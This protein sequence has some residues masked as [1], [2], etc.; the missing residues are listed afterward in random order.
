MKKL[1]LFSIV[2]LIFS[3]LEIKADSDTGLHH[4][5]AEL[6]EIKTD[7]VVEKDFLYNQ[8]ALADTYLYGK[9]TRE[10]QWDKIKACLAQVHALRAQNDSSW[11][12]LQNK[13]NLNGKPAKAKDYSI[14]VYRDVVDR[15]GISSNQAIP[16]FVSD[17]LT[18]PER[19]ALDGSLVNIIGQQGDF[20]IARTT[21]FDGEFLIPAKYIYQIVGIL[22]IGKAIIV[23]KT[24]QNIS[25]YEKVGDVWKVR[26]MNPATTGVHR[27]PYQRETPLGLFV[28]QAKIAKMQYYA[29]GTTEIAG[30]APWANRFSAGGY[31]HGVPVNLPATEII[32]YSGTLGTTP[33]SHMCVRNATSHAKFVY[34]YF[35]VNETLVFVIE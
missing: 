4:P 9:I 12:I 7:V 13:S 29:D 17:D 26:S 35:P 20:V 32:E 2:I 1:T 19:Y 27:P 3:V 33:R 8:Y 18:T 14:D 30:Y 15:Y 22:Q 25:T 24:N 11:A 16:L 21:T 28:L 34:Y 23:D 6:F 31:I 10:F 5:V